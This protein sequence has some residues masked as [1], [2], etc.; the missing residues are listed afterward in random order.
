MS[1]Y[2]HS[3]DYKPEPR[4]PPTREQIEGARQDYRDGVPVSRVL[5]RRDMS[6]G[7]LY[8]W[9]DGGPAGEDGNRLLD[10]IP[11]RKRVLGKR[12]RPLKG[13][14]VSLT[15]RLWRTAELQVRDIEERL[16]RPSAATPERERDVRMLASLVRALRDLKAF[17][18][19]DGAEAEAAREPQPNIEELRASLMRKLQAI[20]AEQDEEARAATPPHASFTSP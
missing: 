9:L 17:D 5:A 4:R 16:A 12:R 7:T 3:F 14:P 19:A 13:D 18:A 6:L 2:S 15:A 10:P 8:Y 20:I 11:R 1:K